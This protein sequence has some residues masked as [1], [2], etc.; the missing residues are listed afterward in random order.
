MYF[1]AKI[2]R[3]NV[4]KVIKQKTLLG[5]PK[6][7]EHNEAWAAL[8]LYLLVISRKVIQ[9]RTLTDLKVIRASYGQTKFW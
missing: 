5:D 3:C 1:Y 6:F 4:T 2:L 9:G 7:K 8:Y